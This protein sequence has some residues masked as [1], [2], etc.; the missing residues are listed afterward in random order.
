MIPIPLSESCSVVFHSLRPHGQY[1]PWTSPGQNTGV[2]SLSLLQG[3]FPA[4]GLIPSLLHCRGILHQL[5]QQGSPRTLEKVV[6]PFS[7]GSSWPRNPT[8]VSCCRWILLLTELSGSPLSHCV[9]VHTHTHTYSIVCL[10]ICTHTHPTSLAIYLLTDS[11]VVE[12]IFYLA[13][14]RLPY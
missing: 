9:C 4:Q 8:A 10:Y 7:R 2:S 13:L 6:C 3:I 14:V 11:E 5:S 12:T 1:S